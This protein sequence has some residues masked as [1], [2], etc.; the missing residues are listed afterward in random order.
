[1]VSRAPKGGGLSAGR[2]FVLS[3]PHAPSFAREDFL[4]APS[5]AAALALVESWPDWPAPLMLLNGPAGAGKSHLAAIFAARTGGVLI[6]GAHLSALDP[7]AAT[8]A[9]ALALDDSEAGLAA[10]TTF[11]H[12]LN[13]ARTRGV[14]MLMTAKAAPS[15]WGVKTPDLLSRLRLAPIVEITAPEPPLIEAAL[16]KMFADRQLSVEPSLVAYVARRL[17]RSL[18]AARDLV[19]ALDAEALAQRRKVTRAMASALLATMGARD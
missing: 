10:E 5:N 11:F 16:T 7:E 18:G 8:S 3:L 14:A 19:E 9:P 15:L 6:E 1:M 12:L 17:D 4:A 13:F 2:Q